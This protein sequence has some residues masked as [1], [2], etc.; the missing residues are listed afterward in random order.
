MAKKSSLPSKCNISRI[1]PLCALLLFCGPQKKITRH[2][3]ALDTII[4]VTLYSSRASAE[5]DLDSL[6]SF[7]AGLDDSLSISK[8]E[9]GIYRINHR[10]DSIVVLNRMLSGILSVCREEFQKGGGLFDVTVAPLKFLYG[11]ESHQ[12]GEY[13]VPVRR[14]ID[15]ALAN[16]GFGR[17]RF[18]SDSVCVLPAG[19]QLDFGGIAKGYVLTR[20]QRFLA[21]KGHA[22]FLVNAGGDLVTRG[23]KPDGKWWSIGI[24]DPRKPDSLV[25]TLACST[26]CVFTSG[27]YERCF[28]QNGKRYHHLFD[29][30]TGLPGWHNMSATVAGS[31]PLETDAVVK[32]AFLMP[33]SEALAYI[34]S[35]KLQGFIIDSAKTGWAS[36]GLR[37][38]L[39]PEPGMTVNFK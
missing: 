32:T 16:I 5:A 11:L 3:A 7:M 12:K 13:H 36:E 6:Q 14:E 20:A 31:D 29:P 4:T 18:L 39:L 23:I 28:I 30:R 8:A 22:R 2:F 21:A 10:T 17:V 25:A 26:G 9:S 34:A 27:D 35:R 19:I 24:Q 1:A 15:T 33:A 38:V 37:G